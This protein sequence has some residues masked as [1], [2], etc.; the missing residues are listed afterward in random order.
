M[1]SGEESHT[2]GHP[3]LRT[4]ENF[5]VRVEECSAAPEI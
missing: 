3:L 5:P 4:L 2:V 1:Q